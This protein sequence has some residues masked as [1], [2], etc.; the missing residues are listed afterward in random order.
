MW[1]S[2]VS[3]KRPVL[4]IVMS[5]ILVLFGLVGLSRLSVREYPDIDPPIVSVTTL[6]EGAS[7][8]VVET[9]ITE[10][11]EDQITS[12]EGIKTL[13]ST[14]QEGA[15]TIFIEFEL[16]RNIDVAAQDVRDRVF[17]ARKQLPN[18]VEEPV[19]LK[20]DSDARP[21][22]WLGLAGEKF[23]QLQLTDYADRYLVDQL[24]TIAG[25]GQVIIGG[26]REYA[27]R[28]WLDPVR[29]AARGVTVLDVRD[30]LQKENVELPSGRIEGQYREFSIRTLGEM[31][32][33]DEFEGLIVKMVDGAPVYLRD[34][35][36]AEVGPR[37]D[38]SL[39][40]MNGATAVGLGV[41][42]QSKANTLDVAAAVKQKLTQIERNLPPGMMI[43]LGYDSSRFIEQSIN[44]VKESLF[45]AILL[46][47]FVIF[48]FLG[49]FR[50]TFIPAVAIPVSLVAT[51]FVMYLLNFSINTLTLLA[52][53]LS[54]GL[55]VDDAIVV[56]ENIY[57]H[58]EEGM[59]PLQAAFIGMREISFAVIATTAV[60]VAIFVPLA[61][62]TGVVGRLFSEFAIALAGAVV[63]S[64]FV[65]LTLSP[66]LCAKT[67]KPG[68]RT[69]LAA[70]VT[71]RFRY[72]IDYGRDRYING[73][74]WAMQRKGL[75]IGATVTALLLA[76]ISYVLLPKE[77]LPKEDRGFLLTAIRAPEGSS[78]AYTDQA[79]RQAEEIY[80]SHPD[81]RRYF[82]VIA[83]SSQGIGSVNEGIMFVTLNEKKA[84][85]KKSVD[86]V[87]NEIFPQM[88]QI[89]E[90]DVFPFVPPTGPGGAFNDPVQ[91]V[92][93][94]FD[95][96]E[97]NETAEQ[98]RQAMEKMFGL[99]N[100]QT[101]LKLNKPQV[102]VV[103]DRERAADMGVSVRDISSTLQILMGGLELSTFQLNNKRYDVVV[104]MPPELRTTPEKLD[105][106]HLAGNDD[107]L[108]PLRNVIRYH[109]SVAPKEIHHYNR[110][111]SVTV[112]ASLLPIP[113]VSLGK[114]M[115]QIEDLSKN[116][117]PGDMRYE[118][119]GE[120]RE[121]R[122]AQS[123]TVFVFLLAV[124][125][126]FLVLA[127]QFES[128]IHPIVIMCT[129]PLAVAGAF[130][131]LYL[132]GN[133][134]NTYSQIGMILL[135]GLV[136]KNGI[137]IVE[138]ANSI[139]ENNPGL[140]AGE[141]VMKAAAIRFRP[142]L[143]TAISTVFSAIPLVLG[144]GAGAESRQS[145]G[146][147]VVGGMIFA[148]LLTL[149]V[150]P[151]VYETINRNRPIK[152]LV[153]PDKALAPAA[154]FMDPA[155]EPGA[156]LT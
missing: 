38:R 72:F 110:L 139:R 7:P 71:D 70:R 46:V 79:V 65:A 85:R 124:L 147:A 86:D 146:L 118:W 4:A 8:E 141:A 95:I 108:V 20:Q 67:L 89:P 13:T 63:I 18:D 31:Q 122:L 42:K 41:V 92:M 76:G 88:M 107:V 150:I 152:P 129:V 9:T 44:E 52:L 112:S 128:F 82:S 133:S 140:S 69:H 144:F 57:R 73:L 2:D 58:L 94:G 49:N 121:L 37:S 151:I 99:Y 48:M 91:F 96:V 5:T 127:A 137:L 22:M 6:Y 104:Q 153:D 74:A 100:T 120:A 102:K 45:I 130:L 132:F 103:I 35:G 25:V 64:S 117:L 17:R 134:F 87:L 1:L 30:A 66:M 3:I 93:Q 98:M 40:R 16:N 156:W 33:A 97:L 47:I 84:G 125:V 142:I 148:T 83:F 77:F 114:S 105:T 60:L 68:K 111:R 75:I 61:F 116:I 28:L 131:T 14:S 43:Q 26:Q 126:V 12:I 149:F 154:T 143:M 29:M 54:I 90:A 19:I 34:I 10:P 11:L 53:T 50:S 136:T 23:S 32:T 115:E 106:L 36:S 78:L 24:Q 39:V 145:L 27:M 15:S 138:Y 21:I 81:I 113:G 51:F 59:K 80:A 119:G 123:A 101:N 155:P 109:E 135:V 62:L 56:L 55:V